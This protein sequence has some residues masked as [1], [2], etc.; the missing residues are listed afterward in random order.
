MKPTLVRELLRV[1]VPNLPPDALVRD[2]L[3]KMD[4]Y[5]VDTLPIVNAEQRLV[6][7]VAKSD[8]LPML[9]ELPL[10]NMR[11]HAEA[12]ALAAVMRADVVT[13]DEMDLATVAWD[14]ML[15]QGH[16]LLPVVS[17]ESYTGTISRLDI[18]CW[19]MRDGV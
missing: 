3:E 17:G 15:T 1:H 11:E 16:E 7:I 6:G 18:I 13:V 10:E 4:L 14:K 2:A 12:V 19:A 8:I 9:I 5:Q